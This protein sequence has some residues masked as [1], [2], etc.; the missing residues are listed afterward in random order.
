[1]ITALM[2]TR[3]A[4]DYSG[5]VLFVE[6]VGEAA[7]RIDR[8][9]MHLKLAGKLDAVAGILVGSFVECKPPDNEFA[10][11]DTLREILGGIGVPVLVNFPAGHAADNWAFALGTGVRLDAD[12]RRIDFLEPAVRRY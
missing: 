4:P 12:A 3:H 10:A 9:L 8:M 2:G 7:Y 6:D 11:S 5:S 1:M